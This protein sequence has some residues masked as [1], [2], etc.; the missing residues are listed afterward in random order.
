[1]N[2]D[3]KILT[4]RDEALK[5]LGGKVNDFA[6][7]GGTALAVVYFQH[8]DSYDLD[9]FTKDFSSK[10]IAEVMDGLSKILGK[11]IKLS[12]QS[13]AK[14]EARI[15]VYQVEGGL[16]VDFIEDTFRH[17]EIKTKY[18]EVPVLSKEAIYLRKIYA[19]CG[20]KNLFSDSGQIVSAG[21]RQEAK[22]YFD[23]YYLSHIFMPLSVFAKRFCNSAETERIILWHSR[24]DRFKIKTEMLDLRTD[25]AIDSRAME[26]H[27]DAEI[28]KLIEGEIG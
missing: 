18:E 23:L 6:L 4:L 3:A 19:A 7:G 12:A 8:R 22:D 2:D 20:I 27:F 1:M 15:I 10:R 5:A 9:F 16:K 11:K 25:Q 14:S 17:F 24:F 21:G 13:D 28:G 26:R